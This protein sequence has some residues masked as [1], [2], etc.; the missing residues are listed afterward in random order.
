MKPLL[1]LACLALLGGC[2]EQGASRYPSLLPRPI[3]ARSDA[4]PAAPPAA[5]ATPDP[6]T[7]AKLATLKAALDES[8]TAF[9]P[10]AD[11]A[12]QAATAAKGQPAGSEGWINAQSMLAELDGYRATT[13][14]SL[15]DIEEM[16]IARAADAQPDYPAIETLRAAAETQLAA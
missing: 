16:A 11:R 10:A 12:E 3:E 1:P 5:V 14:T 9:A 15:T 7:D 4:E 2:A 6:A 8:A 13:S